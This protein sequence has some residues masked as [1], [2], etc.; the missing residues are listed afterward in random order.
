MK[1][2]LNRLRAM[3][4]G[5]GLGSAL[6]ALGTVLVWLSGSE[7]TVNVTFALG[8][9][10]FTA[11]AFI[12]WRT[13]VAHAPPPPAGFWQR[14]GANLANPDWASA[15]I[16]FLGTLYFNVMTVRALAQALG[17]ATISDHGVWHPD[18][19]GSVLFLIA[20]WVAWHPIARERRG[21]LLH[22]RAK[23]ITGANMLGSIFFG[24]SAWGAEP[25][26]DDSIQSVA[27]SNWGT[28]LGALAF[29]TAASL[30]WP[31]R[32]RRGSAALT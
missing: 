28:F 13:A 4:L 27:A 17:N 16:Q 2:D 11:A 8:A 7:V 24:I 22:G 18:Y 5:F 31:F 21:R 12:Q 26:A 15:V 30:S 9:A 20:S 25:M 3:A 1:S 23:W 29:L 10:F 32:A 14:I 6:F 19:V